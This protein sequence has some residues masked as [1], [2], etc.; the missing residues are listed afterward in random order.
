MVINDDLSIGDLSGFVL[1]T[2]T[3]AMSLIGT[4][5]ILNTL[6]T[7]LGVAEKLFEIMDHPT[8]IKSG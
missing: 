5:G 1:Y 6:V 4:G 7:A 3:M 2:I 8:K